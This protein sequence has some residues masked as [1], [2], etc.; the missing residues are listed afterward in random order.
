MQSTPE[1]D[2]YRRFLI[3]FEEHYPILNRDYW[4]HITVPTP[5]EGV[6]VMSTSLE[7]SIFNQ[8]LQIE[9]DYYHP[10][11]KQAAAQ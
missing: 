8:L 5:G 7:P 3:W 6:K 10:W 4:Q 11:N 2:E 1:L 9:F